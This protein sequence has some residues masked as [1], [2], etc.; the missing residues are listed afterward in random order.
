MSDQDI[1][2]MEQYGEDPE[3]LM[4]IKASMNEDHLNQLIVVEEPPKD[5]DAN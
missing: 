1:A 4:A 3:L 2:L 5:A